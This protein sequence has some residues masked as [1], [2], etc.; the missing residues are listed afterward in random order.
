M[1]A[2][3]KD[4]LREGVLA[5]DRR[6]NNDR[7]MKV[8]SR[9][10]ATTLI[11]ASC[12]RVP[13]PEA[14]RARWL[15]AHPLPRRYCGTRCGGRTSFT[16]RADHKRWHVELYVSANMPRFEAF[17]LNFKCPDCQGRLESVTW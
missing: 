16:D 10:T 9:D 12:R 11:C 7:Q 8:T 5:R 3:R 6:F 4:T 15:A 13:D 2:L 14:Y 1:D 17:T